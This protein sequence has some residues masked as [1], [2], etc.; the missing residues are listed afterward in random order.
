MHQ[1]SELADRELHAISRQIGKAAKQIEEGQKD[2]DSSWISAFDLFDEFGLEGKEA[3]FIADDGHVL[4]R[5][6]RSR[7]SKLDDQEVLRAL[8]SYYSEKEVKRLWRLITTPVVDPTKLQAAILA[9]K[10]A[11]DSIDSALPQ[12]TQSPARVRTEWSKQDK[13]RAVVLGVE[14]KEE[15]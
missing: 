10:I 2:F 5:Q 8:Q 15:E 1:I 9:G 3:R 13:N 12:T 11:G 4:A 7:T 6:M 14:K